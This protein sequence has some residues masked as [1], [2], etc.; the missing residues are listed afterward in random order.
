MFIVGARPDEYAGPSGNQ[1]VD[2][3]FVEID[4]A[5]V[6]VFPGGLGCERA[7]DDPDLVIDPTSKRH[8][9]PLP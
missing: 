3:T 6:V 4:R 8:R 9:T 1:T 7:A 2:A 5:D